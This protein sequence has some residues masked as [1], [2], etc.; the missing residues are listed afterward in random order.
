MIDMKV[1]VA[2][3]FSGRVRDAFISRG[4]DAVSCD[5]RKSRRPGPHI[6]GDVR[7]YL[8]KSW[9]LVIAHPPCT[10]LCL[11]GVR[12]L[13]ERDLWEDLRK[14]ASFFLECLNANAPRVAVE[15]PVMHRHAVKLIGRKADF[16]IQPYEFGEQV[17]KK[18]GFWV[19]NLPP[20]TPTKREK[21]Y[22]PDVHWMS[23]RNS[24]RRS[25]SFQGVVD[26]MAEQ[27]G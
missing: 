8:T 9:D 21:Y 6:R 14:A 3:E 24:Y 19:K 10:R 20:L 27:W 16:Y 7:P 2:C 11:S 17:S 1:L 26:A 12:W 15:N 23:S 13:Y 22:T 18:T 5:F 25:I 4:H